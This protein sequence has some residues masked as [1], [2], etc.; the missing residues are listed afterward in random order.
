MK[1]YLFIIITLLTSLV[2]TSCQ[3]E[4]F[5]FTEQEVFGGK[6]KRNFEAKYG[7]IDPNQSW[8][9]TTYARELRLR[10][11]AGT[12]AGSTGAIVDKDGWYNVE[13][14]TLNYIE[15][16]LSGTNDHSNAGS[17]FGVMLGGNEEFEIIP[18]FQ[19]GLNDME[20]ELHMVLLTSSTNKD[21]TLWKNTWSGNN[22]GN[23]QKIK[24]NSA[25]CPTCNGRGMVAGEGSIKCTNCNSKGYLPMK[26][27]G[28]DVKCPKHNCDNGKIHIKCTIC[29]ENHLDQ[30]DKCGGSGCYKGKGGLTGLADVWKGCDQC[31]VK[32]AGW[33]Y[34]KNWGI[35]YKKGNG[36][37]SCKNCDGDGIAEV[38]CDFCDGD[39][40]LQECPICEGKGTGKTCYNCDGDGLVAST[41]AWVNIN[42]TDRLTTDAKAIRSKPITVN[43]TTFGT[44]TE[45]NLIYFYLTIN[46]GKAYYAT[47]GDIQSSLGGKM[48]ALNCPRPSNITDGCEVIMIGCEETT[49]DKSRHDTDYNDLVFMLV[50]KTSLPKIVKYEAS[51]PV[52]LEIKKRYMVEDMGSAVD[53]DFNDIVIDATQTTIKTPVVSGSGNKKKYSKYTETV[54]SVAYVKWLCGTLPMQVTIGNTQLPLITN[55]MNEEQTLKQL[56]KENNPGNSKFD[57]S[58]DEVN[59]WSPNA[60]FDITG[61]NPKNNNIQVVVTRKDNSTGERKEWVASFGRTG[62]APYIIA[63]DQ[64]VSPRGEGVDIPDNWWK[65]ADNTNNQQTIINN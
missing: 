59:G 41:S 34:I 43:S 11:L 7:K 27:D 42:S 62:E 33:S 6:Y 14:G 21:V 15:S 40:W 65:K 45:G 61:W 60:E 13:K 10:E 52:K 22:E 50:G 32:G 4:D 1:K 38:D 44:Q 63:V 53:W 48:I 54:T 24:D 20:W 28:T 16:K 25:I 26:G 2:A 8:D 29:D 39:G 47:S 55:P 51:N 56:A 49:G 35:G 17:S 37:M 12:R 30:C 5:G 31:Q 19:D 58:K 57:P 18:I 9:L 23:F 36:K 64:N 3:D 46:T